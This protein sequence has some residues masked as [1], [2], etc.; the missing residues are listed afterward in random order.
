MHGLGLIGGWSYVE[1][2]MGRVSFCLADAAR[3][4]GAVLATGTPVAAIV[5]D[6]PPPNA[7]A[8]PPVQWTPT[9]QQTS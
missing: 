9:A 6:I 8:L 3:D 1:G 5:P 2:G 7:S 4:A